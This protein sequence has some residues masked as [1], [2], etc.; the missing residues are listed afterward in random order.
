[1]TTMIA[2]VGAQPLPN[3]LPIRQYK[4]ITHVLLVYTNT[5]ESHYKRLQEKLQM[6]GK[7]VYGVQ[8]HPYDMRAIIDKLNATL[9]ELKTLLSGPLEF[10]LTGGTKIMSL[11]AYQVAAQHNAPVMYLQSETEPSTIDHYTWQGHQ[12]VLEKSD[13]LMA[14]ADLQDVLELYL[15]ANKS[16]DDKNRWEVKGPTQDN[17]T[18]GHLFEKAIADTLEEDGYKVLCGVKGPNN[19]LD[20][21]VMIGYHNRIGIIEAKTAG[22]GTVEEPGKSTEANK[23]DSKKPKQFDGKVKKLDGIKQLSYAMQYLRGTYI[24]QFHVIA[25]TPSEDLEMMCKTL[26]IPLISL[27]NYKRGPGATSLSNEDRKTLL[28]AIKEKMRID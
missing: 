23:L 26:G 10:N 6:E 28:D 24:K 11:A 16:K 7:K 15:S 2:L 5:T 27:P 20:I 8:T 12:L 14:Y 21:D 4:K 9:D 17:N 22:D 18:Y 13:T 25:G 3:F 1:M 19:Q